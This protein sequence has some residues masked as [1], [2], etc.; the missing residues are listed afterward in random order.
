MD[1]IYIK[2]NPSGFDKCCKSWNIAVRN[3]L[4]LLFN[5]HVYLLGPLVGQLSMQELLNVRN[6]R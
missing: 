3:L 5:A 1:L 2:C 4:G 6:F